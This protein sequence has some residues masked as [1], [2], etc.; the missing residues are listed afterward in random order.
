MSLCESEQLAFTNMYLSTFS[1]LKREKKKKKTG[2]IE[3]QQMA[4]LRLLSE[5][6]GHFGNMPS[7]LACLIVVFNG[8]P[9]SLR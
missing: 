4:G 6:S 2:V 9:C 5:L 1:C 8:H 3:G 7:R